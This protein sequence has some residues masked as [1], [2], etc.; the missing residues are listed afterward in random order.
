MGE[1]R[2]RHCAFAK[3]S[4]SK[5]PLSIARHCCTIRLYTCQYCNAL[6][7]IGFCSQICVLKARC[8]TDVT[9]WFQPKNC[10]RCRILS[11]HYISVPWLVCNVRCSLLTTPKYILVLLTCA[12]KCPSCASPQCVPVTFFAGGKDRRQISILSLWLERGHGPAKERRRRRRTKGQICKGRW[13][14]EGQQQQGGGVVLGV[15]GGMGWLP[16]QRAQ[17][18]ASKTAPIHNKNSP[19]GQ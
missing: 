11:L 19:N 3:I 17:L 12:W 6:I 2:S 5:A 16:G 14:E 8:V 10:A 1:T 7:S 4:L 18:Y 13:F 15:V 9:L